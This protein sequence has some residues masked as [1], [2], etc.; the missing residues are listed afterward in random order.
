MNNNITNNPLLSL[1]I[2]IL[3]RSQLLLP[4]LFLFYQQNGLTTGDFFLFEGISSFISLLLLIPSGYIADFFSKKYIL[5]ISFLLLLIKSFLWIL[6]HGYFIILLGT[7]L[8]NVSKSLYFAAADSYI[9]EYLSYN[10]R[11]KEMLNKYGKMNFYFSLG[12]AITS[13]FSSIFY[14]YFGSL[15]LLII[16]F[17]LS[18]IATF[19]IFNLPNL[20][21]AHKKNKKSLK[22]RIIEIYA[23]VKNVLKNK[24]I[25]KLFFLCGLFGTTTLISANSFQPIMEL[26]LVPVSLFGIVFFVNYLLR[27]LSGI[28]VNKFQK[29]FD[30]QKTHYVV[31][32]TFIISLFL[33]SFSSAILNKYIVLFSIFISCCAIGLE[34][35]FN[36]ESISYIHKKIFFKRRA[37]TSSIIFAITKLFSSIF[38]SSFKFT[39]SHLSI[40][41]SI[42]L[43]TIIFIAIFYIIDRNF[44]IKNLDN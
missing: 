8:N 17:I 6:F 41:L 10:K 31:F 11:E 9:Y 4:V 1:N 25:N 33:L 18:S 13:I 23:I 42:F 12:I 2:S 36:I 20:P 21:I 29:L 16:D 38:L 30:L 34:V 28:F 7:I 24:K 35:M 14:S 27:S 15:T 26:S 43:Y 44:T 37:A 3:C 5:L 40:S 19:L 39:L 22:Y 32:L